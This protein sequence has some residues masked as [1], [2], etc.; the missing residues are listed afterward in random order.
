MQIL[1]PWD[2]KRVCDGLELGGSADMTGDH[3]AQA[4]DED[5][6]PSRNVVLLAG[7]GIVTGQCKSGKYLDMAQTVWDTDYTNEHILFTSCTSIQVDYSQNTIVAHD[8]INGSA[9]A[10]TDVPAVSNLTDLQDFML[11]VGYQNK[12]D[13]TNTTFPFDIDIVIMKSAKLKV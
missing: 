3:S 6:L 1:P 11:D 2:C 8:C 9:F 4:K 5:N 13:P 10:R 7:E 12:L